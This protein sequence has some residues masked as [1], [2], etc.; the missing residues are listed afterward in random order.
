MKGRGEKGLEAAEPIGGCACSLK[1]PGNY[2]THNTSYK[3]AYLDSLPFLTVGSANGARITLRPAQFFP[4]PAH[5]FPSWAAC[6]ANGLHGRV[7]GQ[8]SAF[9]RWG[10]LPPDQRPQPASPRRSPPPRSTSRPGLSL[11]VHLE[12]PRARSSAGEFRG[13][14]SQCELPSRRLF[15]VPRFVFRPQLSLIL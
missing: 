4:G 9:G 1:G 7:S 3:P 15:A 8:R 2:V 12:Y 10:L 13:T 5:A 11:R 14:G 6:S